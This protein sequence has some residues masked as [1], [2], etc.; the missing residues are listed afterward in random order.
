MRRGLLRRGVAALAVALAV[1]ATPPAGAAEEVPFFAEAV[2]A[3]SLPPV[4]ERLPAVPR[5]VPTSESRSLGTYGGDWRMLINRIKDT[6]LLVVFGYARLVAYDTSLAFVPDILRSYEVEDGCIFTFRLR[7]GHRWSDGAPFTAEDFRYWWED[8]ATNPVLSPS[9]PPTT[10]LVDGRPPVFEVLDD[11]T[12]RFSWDRPNPDFLPALASA[13]PLFIYRPAH[14]MKR[15]HAAYTDQASLDALAAERSLPGWASLHNDLDDLYKFDDPDLPTLQP[16]RITNEPPAQRFVGERNPYFHRVDAQ[17]RQL[18]YMDRVLMDVVDGK[19]VP[20]KS[21]AGESDLQARGLAFSDY[22]FLKEGE[23]HK[24]YDVRL[25]R[26]VRGSQLALYPNLNVRDPVWRELLRD[27]RFRRALSLAINR[28][29]INQV[30]Y[31]GLGIEGQNTVI[32]AS[33]LFEPAYRSAWTTF[34]LDQANALLDAV[35][36]VERDSQGI[37]LLPDGRLL[38][39]IVESAGEDAEEADVLELIH[40]SWLEI[41]V[42]LY[43]KPMQREVLRNRV[44]AGETVMAIWFG[45]EN[46]VPTPSMSP[47]EFAPTTQQLLQWPMWGQF[48]ETG[49]TSGEA[50]DMAEPARLMELYGNWRAAADDEGRRA[51]WEEILRLHA[52]GVYSI[53]LVAGTLQPVV[54][55]GRLNNVPVEGIFNWDPGSQ[56]GMYLPDTFYYTDGDDGRP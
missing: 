23:D 27:V 52:E 24:D 13:S 49:G 21:W 17:G 6:R 19:L 39:I 43:T 30:I 29:E 41:G 55:T 34:D 25:W 38:Q 44:F 33:P 45:L 4:D 35:G 53:G 20:L 5:V 14:Y 3:G 2:A 40:D 22:T 48:H 51:A 56:F 36:L 46:G 18:P 8:V 7:P 37:R 26:T 9:G 54:V 31:Y 28:H 11:T 47:A 32:P 42:K 15:F 16:W 50:I 12:V 1:G 10:M